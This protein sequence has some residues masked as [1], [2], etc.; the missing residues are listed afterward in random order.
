MNGNPAE[1]GYNSTPST[2]KTILP[3]ALLGLAAFASA[4]SNGVSVGPTVGGYFFTDRVVRDAFSYPV[5]SYGF[6]PVPTGRPAPNKVQPDFN[7][8]SASKNGNKLFL[9]PVTASYELQL[10]K[11][12]PYGVY[13]REAA[14]VPFLR[15]L[16]GPAY[17]DYALTDSNGVRRSGKQVGLTAGAVL[18]VSINKR[19]TLSGS[20]NFF[21]KVDQL[22]FSGFSLNLTYSLTRF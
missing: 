18:G 4:Q 10:I 2:M 19:L 3:L 17:Y 14:F 12:S 15:L 13:D 21:S 8:V 20:Y 6:S 22:D 1:E 16:A 7:I 9:L 5:L 11:K